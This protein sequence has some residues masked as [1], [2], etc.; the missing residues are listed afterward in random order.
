MARRISGSVVVITGASSGIGR[1]TALRC[2]RG[3]ASLVLVARRKAAL[4]ELAGQCEK[5][6]GPALAVAADVADPDAVEAAAAQA[7]ERFGRID[8]WVNNAAVTL[9]GRLEQV[10]YEAYRRVIETNLF[11]YIHGARAVLPYFREQGHGTLIN[12]S[13]MVGK[14]GQPFASAY[15]ASKYAI[16]GF[17][18]SL[19][20]ELHDAPE[21]QVCT[22][23]PGSVDTPLFQ[24]GAN[25][26]GRAAKPVEPVYDAD[27]VAQ[28]IVG[29]IERPR[30][31]AMIGSAPRGLLAMRILGPRLA[32]RMF[33]QQVERKHFQDRP[34]EPSA[35]NLFR[36]M[37]Q[38]ASVAGGW[39]LRSANH[40]SRKAAAMLGVAALA[41]G[42]AVLGGLR[43]RRGSRGKRRLTL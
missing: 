18:E 42:L 9:F 3:G 6:G 8:A 24:Q 15:V 17:A 34:E 4:E 37:E 36:P 20:M 10:P 25:Y 19:R 23:L 41:L 32:E 5:L 40:S 2:A 16:A 1:A 31:E 26:M 28:V 11:G 22:V 14:V 7:I 21:I 33:A 39:N 43:G 38:Y 12:L 29:L 35:G 30:R 27:R 13:S